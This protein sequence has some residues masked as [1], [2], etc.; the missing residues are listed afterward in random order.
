MLVR[1]SLIISSP[2][3]GRARVGRV[4]LSAVLN[5]QTS[6][7]LLPAVRGSVLPFAAEKEQLPEEL[8][9]LGGRMSHYGAS[10]RVVGSVPCIAIVEFASTSIFRRADR[11]R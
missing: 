4:S 6:C 11:E 9:S 2:D 7:R 8:R 3:T 5:R 1:A 10:A